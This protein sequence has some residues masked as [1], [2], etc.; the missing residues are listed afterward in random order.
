MGLKIIK[1][2]KIIVKQEKKIDK[3]ELF[4]VLFVILTAIVS[5]VS[6]VANR[7]FVIKI[8]PFIFTTIRSFFIGLIFLVI[9]FFCM[10]F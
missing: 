1:R 3:R 9:S 2:K 4:G 7:L 8:D 10:Q 5:G 6:V